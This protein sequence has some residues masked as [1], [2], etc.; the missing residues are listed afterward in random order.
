[1]TKISVF[2]LGC[3]TNL[4]EGNQI[5]AKLS[6][7]GYEAVLGLE[8]ADVF[9]INTCAIT[10]E[11][12]KK[13]RQAIARAKKINKDC[14]IVVVGC[15]SQKLPEQFLMEGVTVVKGTASKENIVEIIE[16]ATSQIAVDDLP[17]DYMHTVDAVQSR[18]RAFVKIQD[19]C[20][21][22]CSYCI[23]PYL[24]GRSRSKKIADIVRE[25]EIADSL[26][27]VLIGIDISQFGKDT[28]ESLPQLF[29]ALSGIETR[30]RLGSLE[31]SVVTVDFLTALKN[32]NFCPHLHLSLQSG[33]DGVLK[34][35]NRHYT[36]AEFLSS[37][38]LIREHFPEIALTTDVIVG[39]SGETEE[40]FIETCKFVQEVGFA[41]IHIFPYS[42]REGTVAF[43]L[44]DID[45][46]TKKQRVAVLAEIK[47]KLKNQFLENQ[48]GKIESVLI[49]EKKNGYFVGYTPNY[50]RVYI[51]GDFASG[52]IV[53][54]ELI[55]LFRDGVRG[56]LEG[57]K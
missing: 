46:A 24:R 12:E 35:M 55:E 13:S 7:S 56:V 9:V 31:H 3:K 40:E 22:F 2:N 45:S 48:L 32:L 29:L 10:K 23:V 37:A 39:F 49:E 21:N 47:N 52:Q 43:N 18:S 53:E 33:S 5:L 28:N 19:G 34:R 14:K 30:I 26:E 16:T 50:T 4:Y 44:P 15:A 57:E 54:I 36:T 25:V 11:A 38:K 6:S 8:E 42:K 27:T 20:N 17:S 41:D 51:S 1:M